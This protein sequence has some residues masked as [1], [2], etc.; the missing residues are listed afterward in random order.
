MQ[1]L[2]NVNPELI[3]QNFLAWYIKDE[4]TKRW[5]T[6]SEV[7]ERSA[8]TQPNLSNALNWT[9]LFSRNYFIK[10]MKGLWLTTPE[11]SIE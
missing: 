11:R 8:T 3:R 4:I 5:L 7:A 10:V 1:Q 9:K 2:E 6:L